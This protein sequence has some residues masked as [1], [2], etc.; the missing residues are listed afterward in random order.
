MRF[1]FHTALAAAALSAAVA[2][3][4]PAQATSF[5][6]QVWTGFN[7]EVNIP[8]S[9]SMQNTQT[10]E[11][12]TT[13]GD[14]LGVG[15]DTA[16]FTANSIN[17]G[18]AAKKT[19][20]FGNFFNDGGKNP[21]NLQYI[22]LNSFDLPSIDG[23]LLGT[24]GSF[25]NT[26]ISITTSFTG[27]AILSLLSEGASAVF[28]DGIEELSEIGGVNTDIFSVTGSGPH[29]IELDYVENA[30]APDSLV[31][32]VP[33]PA[34]LAFVGAGLIGLAAWRRRTAR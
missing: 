32:D 26:Y 29:T 13:A 33:E 27:P 11:T 20:S 8:T 24:P 3:S 34:S 25:T 1:A 6:G 2:G 10:L 18:V 21:N 16:A 9:P 31:F 22:S 30:G 12:E 19:D 23:V 15:N 17:F 28:V 14:F 5:T 4:S 7:F